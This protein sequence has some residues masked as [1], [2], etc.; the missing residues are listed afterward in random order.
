MDEL[1][2]YSKTAR[3]INLL[4][5]YVDAKIK[6]AADSKEDSHEHFMSMKEVNDAKLALTDHIEEWTNSCG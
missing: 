1:T 2:N 3:L 6:Y 5:V 4:E